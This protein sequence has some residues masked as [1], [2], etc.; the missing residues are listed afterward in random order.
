MN[1]RANNITRSVVVTF[2]IWFAQAAH[3][4]CTDVDDAWVCGDVSE[5]CHIEYVRYYPADPQYLRVKLDDTVDDCRYIMFRKPNH[6]C[7]GGAYTEGALKNLE[8]IMLTSMT[9]GLP[10]KFWVT[11]RDGNLCIAKTAIIFRP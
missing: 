11:E 2:A 5:Q 6:A 9:T 1:T 4:D 10:V 7:T 3:A 8:S